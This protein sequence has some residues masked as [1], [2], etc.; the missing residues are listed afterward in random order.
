MN[1][2]KGR[3]EEEGEEETIRRKWEIIIGNNKPSRE[4]LVN[5]EEKK[6]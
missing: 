2:E 3:E 1:E 5:P 6:T 4:Q